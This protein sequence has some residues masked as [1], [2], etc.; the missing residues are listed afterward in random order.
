M[1]NLEVG[2]AEINSGLLSNG[3]VEQG[4]SGLEEACFLV[5]VN[6]CA[7]MKHSK[8]RSWNEVK[9][10]KMSWMLTELDV[11]LRSVALFGR[12]IGSEGLAADFDIGDDGGSGGIKS[13]ST[14]G[15]MLAGEFSERQSFQRDSRAPCLKS[16]LHP[17]SCPPV[18]TTG[19][20]P[21]GRKIVHLQAPTQDPNIDPN[22]QTPPRNRG[23]SP[24]E[25]VS[26][27]IDIPSSPL[28]P[29]PKS[30]HASKAADRASTFHTAVN[31]VK[32]TN[33]KR[34]KKSFE[35]TAIELQ[36]NMASAAEKREN[37][38]LENDHAR[39]RLD[40]INQ[41][42]SLHK[43]GVLDDDVLRERIR[44]VNE[45]YEPPREPSS[46]VAGPSKTRHRSSSSDLGQS[47]PFPG[48]DPNL[49]SR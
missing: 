40:E 12:Q 28:V 41:L 14:N 26:S 20:G 42:I 2:H 24:A 48:S 35:D 29:A 33:P 45:K 13:Q 6:N 7:I 34:G 3:M 5:A 8:F 10:V 38:R 15:K 9:K 23:D 44:L 16:V 27:P 46:P 4:E 21:E 1:S 47:S 37:A 22:L 43:I 30:S 25:P 32:A 36:V 31:K 19:V 18:L 17:I 39:L 11:A 49:G